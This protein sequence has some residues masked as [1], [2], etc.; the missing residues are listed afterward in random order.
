MLTENGVKRPYIC[1]I[2][3]YFVKLIC[4]HRFYVES[5]TDLSTKLIFTPITGTRNSLALILGFFKF[6]GL[7][8]TGEAFLNFSG[9]TIDLKWLGFLIY[10]A[11]D[12]SEP[13]YKA[14]IEL[15][16]GTID[17]ASLLILSHGFLRAA[18]DFCI[19]LRIC[20]KQNRKIYLAVWSESFVVCPEN[21]M[22]S[23][24]ELTAKT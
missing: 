20:R 5:I 2:F 11:Y 17:G 9:W 13:V 6:F 3:V 24:A 19:I 8:F 16:K 7:R 1:L 14:Y 12:R 18:F 23:K 22:R 21:W 4:K 10:I 15:C